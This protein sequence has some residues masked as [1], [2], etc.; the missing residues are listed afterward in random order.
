MKNRA[1]TKKILIVSLFLL[2]VLTITIGFAALSQS[3]STRGTTN[4]IKASWDIHFENV[5]LTTGSVECSPILNADKTEI[6]YTP[7]LKIPGEY[8]EFSATV[9]NSGDINAVLSDNPAISSFDTTK[10]PYLKHIVTYNDGSQIKA[11]DELN[12]GESKIIKIRV[13]YKKDITEAELPKETES[14][15]EATF[16]MD[17]VQK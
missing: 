10:Y 11:N 14:G 1:N 8:C 16:T 4:V 9:T 17:Y 13:E 15:I 12:S 2:F 7:T 6:L 5:V 3:L